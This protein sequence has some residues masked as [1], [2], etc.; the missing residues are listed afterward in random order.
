MLLPL[1]QAPFWEL[2]LVYDVTLIDW[3]PSGAAGAVPVNVQIAFL[4][5][6][7]WWPVMPPPLTS[8]HSMVGSVVTVSVR[9]PPRLAYTFPSLTPTT[10]PLPSRLALASVA[11]SAHGAARPRTAP[12]ATVVSVRPAAS[13]RRLRARVRASRYLWQGLGRGH[14]APSADRGGGF[15]SAWARNRK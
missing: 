11:A 13:R 6:T 9:S 4:G 2:I 5:W 14:S 8:T 10:V 1:W 3:S 15:E 12:V 7:V